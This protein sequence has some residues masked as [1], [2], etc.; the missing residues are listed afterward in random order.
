MKLSLET[1]KGM[2]VGTDVLV[3][4]TGGA[5]ADCH[6]TTSPTIGDKST[7]PPIKPSF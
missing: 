6:C 7:I 1:L 4:I 3:K 5:R 2:A